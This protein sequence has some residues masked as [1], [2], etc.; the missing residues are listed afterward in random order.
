MT[1]ADLD[2]L[3]L[4]ASMLIPV[5]GVLAVFLGVT[6]LSRVFEDRG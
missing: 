3:A 1:P 4:F 5:A 6:W 2:W